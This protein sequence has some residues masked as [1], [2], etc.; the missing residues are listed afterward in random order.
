MLQDHFIQIISMELCS[1]DLLL[2]Y[3]FLLFRSG[4]RGVIPLLPQY[5]F[6]AWC[7][8]K[9]RDFTFYTFYLYS[10]QECVELY[11][12]SPIRFRGVVLT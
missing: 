9:H 5:V 6:M 4:M 8:V 3:L 11:L 7:L 10:G 12:H 2:H 1:S